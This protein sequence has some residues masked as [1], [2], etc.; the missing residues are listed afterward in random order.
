MAAVPKAF[1]SAFN[2]SFPLA[3]PRHRRNT[4]S[5]D[6]ADLT[7][8]G[9]A[10][11]DFQLLKKLPSAYAAL[12]IETNGFIAFRG[13]LHLRGVCESPAW[14]SLQ[15]VWTGEHSLH[16]Y[17]PGVQ[18]SDIPF[19]QDCL[20]D[21]FL[22]RDGIVHKLEGETGSITSMEL[23]FEDFINRAKENPVDFLLLQPLLRFEYEGASLKPGQ[24]I[25][26]FP[27]FVAQQPQGDFSLS[28]VPTLE[29]ISF[30]A[31]FARQIRDIPDGQEIEFRV[32]D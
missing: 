23:T 5:M 29:R 19:A 6:F 1:S 8:T 17:Y 24:S 10:V 2:G 3:D 12:L 14:H 27:P 25:S 26:V 15:V 18:A 9:P 31:D 22:L 28:P 20:G 11:S 30:L 13:G 16:K 7:F 21:Q 32:V 4:F